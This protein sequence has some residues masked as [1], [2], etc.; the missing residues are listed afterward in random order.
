[1]LDINTLNTATDEIIKLDACS[2][3][4]SCRWRR[5]SFAME[6]IKICYLL[7]IG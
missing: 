4:F 6:I 7:T 5:C 1:L 2:L 3:L